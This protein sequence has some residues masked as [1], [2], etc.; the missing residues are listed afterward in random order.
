MI[1]SPTP[2]SAPTATPVIETPTSAPT[3]TPTNSVSNEIPEPK[4]DIIIYSLNSDNFEK[5]AIPVMIDAGK[6]TLFD[7]VKKIT[8]ALEDESFS[9]KVTNARFE[10][11]TAIVDFSAD[12]TPGASS[13][14][15]EASIL[16]CIAQSIIENYESCTAVVFRIEGKEYVSS[17]FSFG[18]DEAYLIK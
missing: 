4:N 18:I 12:G 13:P 9:V 6:I 17:N 16:D 1:L 10:K 2:T 5:V 15:Y 8:I 7:L 11:T 3:V 14:N